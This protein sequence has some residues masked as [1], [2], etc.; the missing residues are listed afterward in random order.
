M[1]DLIATREQLGLGRTDAAEEFRRALAIAQSPACD[2]AF[3]RTLPHE[4]RVAGSAAA[5]GLPLAGLPVSVKDLFDVQGQVTAAGSVVLA[6]A[7]PAAAD[8][9][10][11]ARLR[12]AG[13]SLVGRT[14]MTEFAF[15]GVGVNPHHGTP[16]NP[17]DAATPRIP[18]GSSS[19]AA[20]SVA[21]GAAFI[22]LGSDTGGSIRIPAALCGIVG[23]KN[24][25]R[26][27][28]LDG[29]LPLSTTLD[30]V[31]AMTRSVRDA[32]LAHE[33]LAARAVALEHR[34]L[35]A[36]R[37]AVAR[38]QM[39]DGLDLPVAQAFE[40]ALRTLRDA[41]ARIEEIALEDIRDLGSIQST[42]GFTAA[43]SYS[44]HR[45]LLDRAGAGYDPRVRTR[46]ERG[47]NMKAWEYL[48]LVRARVDW[49]ARVEA[50]LAG[51]DAVLS[52]TVPIV[53]PPVAEVAPGAERDEAFFRVNGLLL[54]NTS[55]VN[56]L[57]GCAL[58]LPCQAPGSLPVGLML[59]HGAMHDDAVLDAGLAVEAALA[60]GRRS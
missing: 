60:A 3:L 4:A 12:A 10:A 51:F 38:T 17:A 45:P 1:Q 7:P 30:T 9:A 31:C 15:S 55:V 14:N 39:L 16:V 24:T 33:V 11:V 50:A 47:A 26:L 43:E 22:G 29:A 28:P 48:D 20:V 18:G 42:G 34:P 2:K 37:F 23:F 58:S 27:A 59:W 36:R 44:W 32:V 6:D 49:V 53:A 5:A 41:G 56:M 19:G 46:I 57:D 21:T 8:S 25:A 13:A 52:P 35:S 54:R 40:A